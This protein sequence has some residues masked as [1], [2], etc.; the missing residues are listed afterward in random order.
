MFQGKKGKNEPVILTLVD[1]RSRFGI[2]RK[3]PNAKSDTVQ[4]GLLEITKEAPEVF[5]SITFDNGTE[6]SQAASLEK[7]DDLNVKIYFCHAYSAW[8]RGSNENFNKLLRDFIPKGVSINKFTDE[9]VVE[10]A[11]S[12]NQRVREII[13]YQSAETAFYNMK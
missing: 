10:A 2:S 13:D 11:S 5:K 6:F 3:L 7:E 12:V 4:D 9:E 1:R 8:E